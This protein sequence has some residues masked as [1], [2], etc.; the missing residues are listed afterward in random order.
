E[1][2]ALAWVDGECGAGRCFLDSLREPADMVGYL[3]LIHPNRLHVIGS[4]EVAYYERLDD[5]RREAFFVELLKGRPPAI[6]MAEGLSAPDELRSRAHADDLPLWVS[7]LPAARVI[8]RLRQHLGK[9]MAEHTTVHG[10]LMDVLGLGV[11]LQGESGLGKS[12]LAL[13]LISRGHGLVADDAVELA[14]ISPV[15]LEGKCPVLLQNMLEVRGLGLLD[16]R[17]IFGE[18]AVRRKIR[19]RLIVH[20]MR[21]STME[22]EYERLPLQAITQT[23]FLEARD[24]EL[25][26][27]FSETRRRHPL[28]SGADQEASQGL[29]EAIDKERAMLES[30]RQGAATL[31]STGVHPRQLRRWIRDIAA[32]VEQ[33][34]TL[35]LESFAFKHGVPEHAD[36]VFDARCL[37]N[38]HYE[39]QLRALDGRDPA[40][41]NYLEA[42]EQGPALVSS[43]ESWLRRWLP[44]YAQDQRSYLTVAIGCTGGQHRSV[45]TVEQLGSR[46]ADLGAIIR[47]RSLGYE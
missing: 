38:P 9:A 3:N 1:S 5:L 36:L 23:I 32:T 24:H 44:E 21:R 15:L 11:L 14:R 41:A 25:L 6:V 29:R 28:A 40:V 8:E 31:D 7:P 47:H 16:I 43:I 4:N 12:E 10:V 37:P 39:D 17:T 13:E 27:R 33:A 19:L 46:L 34:I 22:Q 45:W 20:L 2:L 30:V 18:A 42:S 26:A 35:S